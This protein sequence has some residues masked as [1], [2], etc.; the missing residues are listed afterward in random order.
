MEKIKKTIHSEYHQ[1]EYKKA[2]GTAQV[3]QCLHKTLSSNPNTTK[4]LE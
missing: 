1:K 2:K 3:V 4:N